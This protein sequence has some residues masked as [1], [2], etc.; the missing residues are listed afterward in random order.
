MAAGGMSLLRLASRFGA[1]CF[2]REA[3]ALSTRPAALWPLPLTS[4]LVFRSR[5]AWSVRGRPRPR[6][7][8]VIIMSADKNERN[9]HDPSCM[10]SV[11]CCHRS[12]GQSAKLS[13]LLDGPT[14]AQ[15]DRRTTHHTADSSMRASHPVRT[16]S[17]T[18]DH[19]QQLERQHGISIM[20]TQQHALGTCGYALGTCGWGHASGHGRRAVGE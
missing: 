13:Q 6:A 12:Q 7:S 16:A 19:H 15:G 9:R 8:A 18:H 1:W 14:W 17:R 2:A 4:F 11:E 3:H 10:H 5:I 20:G